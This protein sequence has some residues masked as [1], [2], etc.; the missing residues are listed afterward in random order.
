MRHEEEYLCVADEG[1][2]AHG[3]GRERLERAALE[4]RVGGD[5][6]HGWPLQG[7][8]LEAPPEQVFR[9]KT[10]GLRR[11]GEHLGELRVGDGVPREQLREARR[12]HQ[13]VV[14][15]VLRFDLM[16]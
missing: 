7:I 15:N 9:R 5:L 16:I 11:V 4:E 1:A 2:V 13:L 6:L 8:A 12:V 10:D 3:H 14:R